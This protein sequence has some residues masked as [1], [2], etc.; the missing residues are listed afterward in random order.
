MLSE[1]EAN[2][3]PNIGSVESTSPLTTGAIFN[4][5]GHIKFSIIGLVETVIQA[6]ATTVKLSVVCDALAAYDICATLDINGFVAGSLLGID[7]T[8]GDAM[9][10]VSGVGVIAPAES[11]L[12]E[13]ECITSGQITVTFGAAS[14]GAIKWD[15]KW[16]AQGPEGN[17]TPS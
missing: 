7:G 2:L 17:V 5:T 12:V 11:A 16:F 13:A 15:I 9:E 1:T 10:G 3:S 8:P 6:Q 4:F 14:T